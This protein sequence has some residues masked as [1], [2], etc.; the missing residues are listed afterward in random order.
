MLLSH[1]DASL[2]LPSSL[3]KSNEESVLVWPF[4]ALENLTTLKRK[5]SSNILRKTLFFSIYK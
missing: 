3:S 5:S 2:S 1:V 4:L